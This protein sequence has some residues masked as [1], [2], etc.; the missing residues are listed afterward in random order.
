M[1]DAID[2]VESEVGPIAGLVN[3]AGI[4]RDVPSLVTETGSF[5]RILEINLLGSFVAARR[6][7][8]YMLKRRSGSI[9]N[10]ASVSGIM[11]NAG[12]VAY[13]ASKGGV[14]TM[15]RVMAVELA[16]YGVRVNALAPGPVETALTREMHTDATRQTWIGAVPMG[17][18]GTTE[19]IASVAM[20]LLRDKESSYV[21]GQ[22]ICADGGFTVLGLPASEQLYD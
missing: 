6:A 20:F 17:R 19:E 5:R 1:E 15:T 14:I 2:W 9:V 18:Y 7:A 13:G 11:G 21:T 4:G 10:I 3:S 8:Q 22:T 12:R 16:P